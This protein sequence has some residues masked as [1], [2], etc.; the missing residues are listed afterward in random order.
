M[1]TTTHSTA[2]GTTSPLSGVRIVDF[3]A[4]MAGPFATQVLAQQGAAVSGELSLAT[5][6]SR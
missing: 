2:S 4:D 5:G 6:T 3:T 1:S